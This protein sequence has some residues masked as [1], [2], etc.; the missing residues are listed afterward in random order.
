MEDAFGRA[1][2]GGFQNLEQLITQEVQRL[3]SENTA[4]VNEIRRIETDHGIVTSLPA[5]LASGG[6]VSY[7][8][9]VR[10]ESNPQLSDSHVDGDG[11][12]LRLPMPHPKGHHPHAHHHHKPAHHA[13]ADAPHDDD[14]ISG[15]AVSGLPRKGSMVKMGHAAS[16]AADDLSTHATQ[17]KEFLKKRSQREEHDV[18]EYYWTEEESVFSWMAQH[19]GMLENVTLAVVVINGIW[20][21]IDIDLNRPPLDK[22]VMWVLM[23]NLF[24]VYFTGELVVRFFAFKRKCNIFRSGW[25][26]FDLVLVGMMVFET[27]VLPIF[28]LISGQESGA[29]GDA[30]ILR[31][32]RLLRLSRMAK[33]MRSVPELMILIKGTVVGIRSVAIT[34][35]LLFGITCVFAIAIRALTDGTEVGDEKFPNVPASGI[36]LLIEGVIPDNGDTLL[37]LAAA[38]DKGWVYAMLFFLFIFLAALTFMNMLIGILCEAVHG[39]SVDEREEMDIRHMRELVEAKMGEHDESFEENGKVV[40]RDLFLK[41]LNNQ[42]DAIADALLGVAVDIPS[43]I[44]NA[45]TIFQNPTGGLDFEDFVDVILK[46]RATDSSMIKVIFEVRALVYERMTKVDS[47][48]TAITDTLG[49]CIHQLSQVDSHL[50]TGVRQTEDKDAPV[51]Q[52]LAGIRNVLSEVLEVS[53]RLPEKVLT[54]NPAVKEEPQATILVTPT[55]SRKDVAVGVSPDKTNTTSSQNGDI[56]A[57]ALTPDPLSQAVTTNPMG[58]SAASTSEM[59]SGAKPLDAEAATGSGNGMASAEKSLKL[60]PLDLSSF[61]RNTDGLGRGGAA[62]MLQAGGSRGMEIGNSIIGRPSEIPNKSENAGERCPLLGE[63]QLRPQSQAA[64]SDARIQEPPPEVTSISDGLADR[65]SGDRAA[66]MQSGYI[67]INFDQNVPPGRLGFRVSWEAQ[68]PFAC[69]V[70]PGGKADQQGIIPGD[71]LTEINGL[72][73]SGK[74]KDELFPRLSMRPLNLKLYRNAVCTSC[75]YTCL[76]NESFCTKCGTKR[77]AGP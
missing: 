52:E 26:M 3:K 4:L 8:H 64:T 77:L 42:D 24:C 59:Q 14:E 61:A 68:Q 33:M 30:Q 44:D 67:S 40:T 12:R 6:G 13:G 25:F 41:V 56:H 50:N 9:I 49:S 2:R 75:G 18:T 36:T 71:I 74:T 58:P 63:S 43:L 16:H 19:K 62:G 47:K 38:D 35:A 69:V 11:S 73:T 46:F 10:D 37:N 54:T 70:I 53:L 7:D 21:A 23:D 31:L 28:T 1:V 51:R 72:A 5:L 27:W 65:D 22:L 66:Q 20:I 60:P 55:D 57:A 15:K 29:G 76:P 45:N 39:V 32:L 48:L 17:I 34:L